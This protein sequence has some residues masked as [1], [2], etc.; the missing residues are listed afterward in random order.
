MVVTPAKAI[1]KYNARLK[2]GDRLMLLLLATPRDVKAL[3]DVPGNKNKQQ[4]YQHKHNATVCK[5]TNDK[6]GN[7]WF[8]R[9]IAKQD[10]MYR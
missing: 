1:N 5:G 4:S 7:T 3:D 2:S 6:R 10:R 9:L 8:S